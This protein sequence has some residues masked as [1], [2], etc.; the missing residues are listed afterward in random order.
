MPY[1]VRKAGK[2]YNIVN[3]AT[4]KKVGRSKTKANA[5]KS[6]QVRNAIDHGWKPKR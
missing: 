4:G 6:A 1:G 2:G 3:K 5:K